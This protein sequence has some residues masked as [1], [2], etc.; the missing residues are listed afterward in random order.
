MQ[1]IQLSHQTG[2]SH[3]YMKWRSLEESGAAP[4]ARSLREQF[5][6]RKELIAKYVPADTQAI[7]ARVIADL[8]V[9]GIESGVLQRGSKA[10]D[11][12]LPDHNG[13]L[14]SSAGLLN[15][16]KL[17]ICFFRGRW[18]PFCVGQL[19]AMQQVL[20]GIQGVGARLV[21][22]SPQ[23]VQQNFFMA[24]QHRLE[25]PLLSD[26]GN[27]VARQFGLIYRVREEQ[28]VLYRR[29]FVNLP[30]VNGDENWELPIPATYIV[31]QDGRVLFASANADYTERPEPADVVHFLQ[32]A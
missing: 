26:T 15:Q 32:S 11:F 22:V 10:P 19:E 25:F 30:F 16:G 8:K 5:A 18:C 17:V 2:E 13:K 3:P 6:D 1:N 9:S 21:A 31:D 24:D 27:K 20:P 29:T 4:D 23:T 12:E 14:V 7:H 28:Q